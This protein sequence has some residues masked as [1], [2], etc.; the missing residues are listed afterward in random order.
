MKITKSTTEKIEWDI[1]LCKAD[2]V[3]EMENGRLLS[4]KISIRK[5]VVG[6]NY[7]GNLFTSDDLTFIRDVHK[8]LGDFIYHIDG[9]LEASQLP[10]DVEYDG[11]KAQRFLMGG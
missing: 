2:A 5:T 10:G 9:S 4:Q 3:I 7:L 1:D 11:M 8:A 6:D